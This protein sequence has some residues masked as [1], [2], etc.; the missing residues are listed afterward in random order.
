MSPRDG[1]GLPRDGQAAGELAGRLRT[2]INR[3]AFHLRGPATRQGITPTRLAAMAALRAAG[4]LRPGDL[5]IR[6]G[7]SAVSMS[8]LTDVLAEGGLVERNPDPD[9]RRACLLR[10]T[11]GG[12]AALESLRQEGTGQLRE[13]LIGLTPK[14]FAA[15]SAALPILESLADRHL[16]RTDH[17]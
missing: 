9:D 6:L 5:A 14:E 4:T 17:T 7:I 2:T 16:M 1:Y 13:D 10:L 15:L 8:R 12:A 11:T 3:L